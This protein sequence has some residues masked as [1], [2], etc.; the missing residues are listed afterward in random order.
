VVA[1]GGIPAARPAQRPVEAVSAD[2]HAPSEVSADEVAAAAVVEA[3]A[4]EPQP[5][6]AP[7]EDARL[8]LAAPGELA[9]A[10]GDAARAVQLEPGRNVGLP[11]NAHALD[12]DVLRVGDLEARLAPSG[13]D[14]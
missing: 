12:Q 10:D 11:A 14:P 7:G 6:R 8:E 4:H 3:V 2:E 5:A 1:D 13:L 9:P